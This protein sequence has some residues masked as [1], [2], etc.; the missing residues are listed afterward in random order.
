VSMVDAT[1][2]ENSLGLNSRQ[3]DRDHSKNHLNYKI[4]GDIQ[5]DY[6]YKIKLLLFYLQIDRESIHV[7]MY[8]RETKSN[9]F[10]KM[11]LNTRIPVLQ[12]SAVELL[13]DSNAILR[14]LAD[15]SSY[16]PSDPLT[17]TKFLQ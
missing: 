11:N 6:C 2:P 1:S 13:T 7:D 15:G 9:N 8:P 5:L 14:F 3:A 10:K 16:L 4:Y 17:K 12:I